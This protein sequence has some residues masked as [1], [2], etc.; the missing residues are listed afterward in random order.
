MQQDNNVKQR[1]GSRGIG[2]I[3]LFHYNRKNIIL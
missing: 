2:I 1:N 3:F